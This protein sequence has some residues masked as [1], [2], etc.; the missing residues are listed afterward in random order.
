MLAT[1]VP[2]SK[3]SKLT[4]D[5]KSAAIATTYVSI[6]ASCPPTCKLRD[7]GCYGQSGNVSHTTRRLDKAASGHAPLEAAKS[8][9]DA[10]TSAI[11]AFRGGMVPQDGHGGRGRDLRLH[12]V[13]DTA[14]PEAAKLIA[15]AAKRWTSKCGS[16]P[17]GYTHAWR[18][19]TRKSFGRHVSM[20]A[21]IDSPDEL[22]EARKRGYAVAA[23]TDRF[24]SDRV[25]FDKSLGSKVLP[26]PAQTR[27]NVS[28]VSCR[29]CMNDDRLKALGLVVM[30]EA[31]GARKRAVGTAAKNRRLEVIK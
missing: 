3:N 13:G 19:V 6:K 4:N 28:C 10:I 30:F 27:E 11:S 20:L 14:S 15:L 12:T 25:Y 18:L 1:F 29:M 23:Y 22:Q 21:S 24:E 31:H 9:H 2:S 7:A 16:K 8:E 17:Y 26:C 5:P